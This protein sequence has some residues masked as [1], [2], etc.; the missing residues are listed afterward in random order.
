M[1]G[2]VSV[3]VLSDTEVDAIEALIRAAIRWTDTG[4][5]SKVRTQFDLLMADYRRQRALNGE[6]G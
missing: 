1:G 3:Q 6:K 4:P 5:E 2:G